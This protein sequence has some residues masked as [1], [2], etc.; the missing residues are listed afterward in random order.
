M[1]RR[2]DCLPLTNTIT[3][4]MPGT[5]SVRMAVPT[6]ESV[7]RMP[8][9]ARIDVRPAKSAEPKANTIHIKRTGSFPL[10]FI[11]IVLRCGKMATGAKMGRRALAFGGGMGYNP[12]CG[13]SLPQSKPYK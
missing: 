4:D 7:S 6:A 12:H 11:L 2:P 8:H 1:C 10:K 13:R 9:L 3:Q 5:T